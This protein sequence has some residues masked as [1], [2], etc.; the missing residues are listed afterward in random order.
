MNAKVINAVLP[1]ADRHI[2]A[3]YD[4]A[5]YR[6]RHSCAHILAQAVVE[7]FPDVKLGIGP[8]IDDGFYYDFDLPA[9]IGPDDLARIEEVMRRI[10][11]EGH[12]FVRR[13]P[14]PAE[15]RER[16][17]GQPYKLDL[18]DSLDGSDGSLSAYRQDSFEDL[19][20]GPHVD[21]TREIDPDAVKLLHTAGAYWRGDS[22]K[23]MLQRIYGTAWPTTAELGD[24]LNRVEE[25][26]KRD[27]RYIGRSRDLFSTSAAVGAGLVLWHPKAA[28][29]RFLAERF[30]QEAHLLNGYEWV[31]TPHIGR[32]CLWETSGHLDFYKDSMYSP[33]DIDGE[34]YYLKPMSCP[35][36]I[37]IFKSRPRSYREL[38]VR[39]AEYAQVYRYELSGTLHGMTR[40]RG[41]CQ[42]DAH[43]FC[44]PEQVDAEIR[45]A[46]KFSLYVLRT[47]GLTDFKAYVSTRGESK[48]IG[49]LED[50]DRA[51]ESLKAA[52]DGEGLAYEIDEGGA[53]FYGP[54]IDLKVRDSLGREWQ[55]STIQ[56]DFNLPERF[57]LQYIGADGQP[58]RPYMVHRALFG[59]AERFFAMLV[60][61]YAGAFPLWLAPVQVMIIPVTD[62]QVD[63]ARQIC[64]DLK[65]H[66]LR[67]EVDDGDSRM[68]GKIR[69]AEVERIPYVL[70][71]GKKE[72]LASTVSVRSREDGDIGPMTVDEFVDRTKAEREATTPTVVGGLP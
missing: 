27:H 64:A 6:L 61:H 66:G 23:P 71:V 39:Y 13:E 50:W 48:A 18:I 28:M 55:L 15:L 8:P 43:T 26:K 11:R 35:F 31:Y 19:C 57:G 9:S 16:F 51:V 10:I 12:D 2:P 54:K 40:V 69:D 58:H 41:F 52:V 5:L 65:R 4:P 34:Q 47:F 42:D 68:S 29:V 24:Y 36:H 44:L 33:I 45:H 70:V 37:E 72:V 25:S 14:S 49:A 46:L 21:N 59:S 67:T 20:R 38:P 1:E 63:Y 60:E 7:L 30:S 22:S 17:A 32:S 3:G 62:Q 56:F 53:A